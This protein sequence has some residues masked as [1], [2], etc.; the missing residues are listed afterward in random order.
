[1][2]F[3]AYAS[4]EL[5]AVA[6]KLADTAK[7]QLETTTAQLTANFEATIERLRNDQSQVVNEN[8]RLTAENAALSWEKADMLET[9]KT[10]SRGPLIDRLMIAFERIG[11][12]T[13]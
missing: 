5:T 7:K 10:A 4:R 2:D 13:T 12:S 9:A 6:D 11:S 1:M 8:E 3:Q